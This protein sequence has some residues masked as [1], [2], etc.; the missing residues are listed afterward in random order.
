MPF[1]RWIGEPDPAEVNLAAV[2]ADIDAGK[3]TKEDV[4]TYNQHRQI[5]L[6]GVSIRFLGPSEGLSKH[7][8]WG[9]HRGSYDVLVTDRDWKRIQALPEASTFVLAVD[10]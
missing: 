2:Q 7:Y 8:Q 9:P 3:Y 5:V 6:E 1:V 10:R 4:W